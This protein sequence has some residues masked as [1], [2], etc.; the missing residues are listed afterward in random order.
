MGIDSLLTK[1]NICKFYIPRMM[2]TG[3]PHDPAFYERLLVNH[4]RR[5]NC[6]LVSVKKTSQQ[7][8]RKKELIHSSSF[9]LDIYALHILIIH[10]CRMSVS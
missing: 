4:E 9:A 7:S 8:L 10:Y 1:I 6:H 3:K 5:L 2:K